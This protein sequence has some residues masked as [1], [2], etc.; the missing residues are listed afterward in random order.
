MLHSSSVDVMGVVSVVNVASL[1]TVVAD[2][3]VR[4]PRRSVHVA[5]RVT[6]GDD[7]VPVHHV[8]SGHNAPKIDSTKTS[9]RA[10][11]LEL[12]Q[13]YNELVDY[14]HWV[15]VEGS[16]SPYRMHI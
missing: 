15:D 5:C 13:S 1:D 3:A 11:C 12:G 8:Y 9:P 6:L 10:T 14:Q 4:A 2:G 16:C 7:L